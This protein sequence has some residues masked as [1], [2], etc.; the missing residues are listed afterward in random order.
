MAQFLAQ[1]QEQDDS[2]PAHIANPTCIAIRHGPYVFSGSDSEYQLF[3]A[4]CNGGTNGT[5][6]LP[7]MNPGCANQGNAG[8]TV[9]NPF[10]WDE[11]GATAL[12]DIETI[13]RTIPLDQRETG[14]QQAISP[15]WCGNNTNAFWGPFLYT[16]RSVYQDRLGTNMAKS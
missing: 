12:T 1:A 8:G 2:R 15:A 5:V 14:W 16:T 6:L 11:V 3:G 13:N 9:S 7:G 10:G 4:D